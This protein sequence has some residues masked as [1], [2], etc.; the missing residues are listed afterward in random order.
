MEQ[1]QT[2]FDADTSPDE[3]QRFERH[4]E[5]CAVCQARFD[6]AEECRDALVGLARQFGDPTAEPADPTLSGVLERLHEVRSPLRSEL[7]EPA[8]L[9][10]L[11]ASDQP[12][13]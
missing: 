5:S 3:R 4:L 1:W 6:S 11:R 8:D 9:Y 12:E 2:L 13:L 10:F 7:A